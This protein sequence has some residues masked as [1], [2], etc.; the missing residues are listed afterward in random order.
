MIK[1]ELREILPRY[2]VKLNLSTRS[3]F[4][5]CGKARNNIG[6]NGAITGFF[7]ESTSLTYGEKRSISYCGDQ[8]PIVPSDNESTS[9]IFFIGVGGVPSDTVIVI[10]VVFVR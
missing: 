6:R 7:H 3:Y 10:T 9:T 5:W 2:D 8:A 1:G 4:E